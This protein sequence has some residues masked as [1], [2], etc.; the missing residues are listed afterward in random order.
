MCVSVCVCVCVCVCVHCLSVHFSHHSIK[1][2]RN[3][4]IRKIINSGYFCFSLQKLTA[5]A[6]LSK[7]KRI[8]YIGNIKGNIDLVPFLLSKEGKRRKLGS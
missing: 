6:S 2:V 7:D 8:I 4:V 3:S 5:I 1:A